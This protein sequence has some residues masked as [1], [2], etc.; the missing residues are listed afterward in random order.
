MMAVRTWA[1]GLRAGVG[2]VCALLMGAGSLLG[3]GVTSS[4]VTGTVTG[5]DGHGLPGMQVVVRQTQTGAQTG[6]LTRGDGRYYIQGLQPGGPYTIR[7]EGLGYATQQR[8]GINLVLSQTTRLDF[9]LSQKAVE[10]GAIEVTAQK[11]TEAI[12]PTR[13]A[14]LTTISDSVMNRLPSLNRN[15]TDFVKLTPQV[16]TTLENGGLSGGGVN[17]RYNQVQIDGTTETDLF[18]LGS[19]GQPGGQAN[20]KSIGIEAVK[21]YQVLLTPFDVRY[22]NFAGLL[23]NA[24]TKSGTNDLHGSVYGYGRNQ[25]FARNQTYIND[26]SQYQYGASLGGPVVKDKVMFF[27]NAEWQ[28]YSTPTTGVF[29]GSASYPTVTQANVDA[30]TAAL[31]GYGI[32]TGEAGQVQL[33]NPLTNIFAR[34]DFLSLPFNTSMV[35]RY[36]YSSATNQALVRG[37]SGASP[38]LSL[39]S[40]QYQYASTKHAPAIELRTQ[41]KSGASNEFRAAYTRIRDPRT[42]VSGTIT[43]QVTVNIPGASLVGGTERYSQGNNVEQDIFD[44]TNN[45]TVPVGSHTFVVGVEDQIFKALN[46]YAQANHGVWQFDSLDSL[47]NGQAYSYIVGVPASPPYGT[48]DGHVQF[49]TQSLA[50]YAQDQWSVSPNLTINYGLRLDL[51]LF[52]SKPPANPD[53]LA[54]FGRSTAEIPS[55]NLQ[56]SPRAGFNWDVTGDQKNQLRG[57]IG[58][59]T[60]HPA[61]VWLSNAFQNSGLTGVNLLTCTRTA[62]TFNAAAVQQAPTACSNGTTA[63]AG[64]EVDL[65]QPGTRM[66]QTLRGSLGYDR[67][68]GHNL[69]VTAEGMYTK[70]LYSPF[71][72]NIALKGQ[73]NTD[74]HG[75]IMYGPQPGKPVLTVSTRNTVID[76]GNESNDHFYNLTAQLTR[77]YANHWQG[78]AAYTYSRGWDVQSLSSSTAISN[79]RYGRVWAGD[80]M[81]KTATRSLFEQRH[82]VVAQGSYTFPTLTTL[83]VMYTGASGSPYAFVYSS[84]MNGDGQSGNDPIYV[85]KDINDVNEIQFTD[86]LDSKKQVVATVA[87][88]KAAFD[89]FINSNSCL[90]DQRGKIMERNSCTAPFMH[91]MNVSLRQS[92][93]TFRMQNVSVQLDI[94]NFLNMVNKN[95]GRYGTPYSNIYLLSYNGLSKGSSSTLY[96]GDSNPIVTYDPSTTIIDYK[97]L[98]SNYQMQM[99]VRY[100][101]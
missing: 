2:V 101:F 37:S 23:I 54:G 97:N 72:T 43:P 76:V 84:D 68:I 7:V 36:N 69:V 41:F 82:R 63:K 46:L 29:V 100:N 27:A 75:R 4:A 59:F 25:T 8:T 91:Q 42:S 58:A 87:Q 81:D 80:Q 86:L 61:Y 79:W 67:D 66:P 24:V 32:P 85:P 47:R 20:G 53:I 9:Q 33:K 51:P 92:L 70:G 83:S 45:F 55:G 64:G 60:G 96:K 48:S 13:T 15:F 26:F 94:F 10:L 78:S 50:A 38:T 3:Q 31:Q 22:G 57:G 34:L 44:I 74:N 49:T 56:W 98:T 71:Y 17:N 21:E 35:V 1:R 88:E 62:P 90:K 19:T 28:A 14:I 95:W 5:E 11:A 12:S 77:R 99:S 93:N 73:Q 40:N 89:S 39:T 18:G 16:S 30:A 6:A 65:V 52:G